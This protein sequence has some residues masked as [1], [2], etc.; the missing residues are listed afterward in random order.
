MID[1]KDLKIGNWYSDG[2]FSRDN[3]IGFLRKV[4]T[5]EDVEEILKGIDDEF[6]YAIWETLKEGLLAYRK[7]YADPDTLMITAPDR[8]HIAIALI[9]HL[10]E[11]IVE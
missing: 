8:R 1:K 11:E 2:Q 3:L 9:D 4:E 7:L 6:E 10:L 5:Q